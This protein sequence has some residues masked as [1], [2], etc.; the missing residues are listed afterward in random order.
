MA[1]RIPLWRH[2]ADPCKTV[3]PTP[4][5]AQRDGVG[6]YRSNSSGV[7]GIEARRWASTFDKNSRKP[8]IADRVRT[9]AAVRAGMM[10][11]KTADAYSGRAP[12][13]MAINE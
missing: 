5:D 1:S 7:R 9:P 8:R 4:L 2:R 10:A 13:T 12:V 3:G 11:A 6:Q